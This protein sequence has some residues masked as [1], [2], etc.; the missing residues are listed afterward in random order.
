MKNKN[1]L[2]I[3]QYFKHPGEP[4]V[5][6]SYWI[7]QALIDSGYNVTMLAHKNT[8]H[9]FV[10]KDVP[11]VE[12]VY[13][14]RIRVIYVKN[15]YDNSM[16]TK[17]RIKSFLRFMFKSSR[18]ALKLKDIDLVIA[19][20]TPLTVAVP[21]LLRKKLKKTPYIFEVRD[22]WPEGPIQMGFIKNKFVV[23]FLKWLEKITY[24]NAIHVVAL[25]PGMKDGV[26]KYINKDNISL[27]PNMAKID[28]FGISEIN[29][30]LLEKYNLKRDTFKVVYF[31]TLGLANAIP[32][33]LESIKIL[34]EDYKD[35]IEFIFLGHG[36]FEAEIDDFINKNKFSNVKRIG[37]SKLS[38][39]SDIVNFSDVSLVTFS[40]IPI[41]STN[42]PNKFFDSLSAGKPIIVNS[43]GWTKD[44]IENYNCGLFASPNDPKDL[45]NKISFLKNN[46]I[47]AK[48]MGENS[49]KLAENKYDKSILTKKFVQLVDKL[50]IRQ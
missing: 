26:A 18:I 3:N 19:T 24:K 25:S 34:N 28:K 38:T 33:I 13:I 49:R 35:E 43:P 22:L 44:I 4:G 50:I 2:Y 12:E 9:D 8:R 27:I 16:N 23:K 47:I 1:I 46:P 40:D 7:A 31:G 5:G 32:Y 39:V 42:S 17:E 41:L 30:E 10:S 45:A 14:D 48:E 37:R 11:D 6:R 29:F 21:A 20:S 15:E 36:K